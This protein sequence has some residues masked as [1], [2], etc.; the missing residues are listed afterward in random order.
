MNETPDSEAEAHPI[1]FLYDL[2][3]WATLFL[4]VARVKEKKNHNLHLL[5]III[6]TCSLPRHAKEI[7]RQSGIAIIFNKLLLI[8]DLFFQGLIEFEL[9]AFAIF[10]FFFLAFSICWN[11]KKFHRETYFREGVFDDFNE[12]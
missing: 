9:S 2:T 11:K 4:C 5:K 3:S 6:S 10:F 1:D 8:C 12:Q 7:P